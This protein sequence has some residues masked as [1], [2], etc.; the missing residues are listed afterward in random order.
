M[1]I[2]L[3]DAILYLRSD[4]SGLED[5]LKDA[6]KETRGWASNLGDTTK[7]LL[8]GAIVGGATVAAGAVVG[9]GAA[10]FT[11]SSNL[12][13][14]TNNIQAQLG[15]TEEEAQRLGDVAHAVW[16][17]NFGDDI[18]EAAAAVGLIRQQLGDLTDEELQD[19]AEAAFAIRDAFGVDVVE[20][21][22]AARTLMEDFGLTSEEAMNF[23]ASGFQRGL[24]RSGDFLDTITEYSTQFANGGADASQFFSLMESGLQGGMLGTDKAADAFKEFRVRIQDGSKATSESLAML[25]IDANQLATAMSD[26]TITAADAWQLV[27]ERLN[28]VDDENIRMQAGVGLL[29]TQFEDLGTEAA[30][31]LSLAGTSLEELAGST[32]SLNV[33]YDNWPAMWESIKR[34]ITSA[35]IPVGDRLLSIANDA[36]PHVQAAF[37]WLAEV[38]P[39]WIDTALGVIT[40]LAER[41][42]GMREQAGSNLEQFRGLWEQVRDVVSGIVEGL[43]D[44]IDAVFGE[45]ARFMEENGNSIRGT[46][47]STWRQIQY[48]IDL[49]LQLIDATI[50]PALSGIADFIRSHSDE[51]QTV[52]GVAWD[53]IKATVGTALDIIAGILEAGLTIIEGDWSGAWEAI[54][55]RLLDI[56]DRWKPL[57]QSG[58]DAI[59]SVLRDAGTSLYNAG[60]GFVQSFWD[61]IAARWDQMRDDFA[62]RLQGIRDLLPGSEPKD[63]SSPLYGLKEAGGAIVEN[64]ADGISDRRNELKDALLNLV[65]QIRGGLSGEALR[66]A[67]SRLPRS[68]A[69]LVQMSPDE[70]SGLF[71]APTNVPPPEATRNYRNLHHQFKWQD[72]G[73]VGSSGPGVINYIFNAEDASGLRDLEREHRV[74][75]L[76]ERAY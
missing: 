13:D 47:E 31:G 17:N 42:R 68:T 45:V 56:V 10:A 67:Y 50:G 57:V 37:T 8:T 40:A 21:T 26:G 34:S 43:G 7:T 15:A 22:D 4:K 39:G 29:G 27:N 76:L 32:E 11:A 23:I 64:V 2:T 66:A 51:I 14:A 5:G 55:N 65:N 20:S 44:L 71:G 30:L 6:E 25:G 36:M 49:A 75:T 52:L 59:L 74:R 19:A 28:E 16:R 35:L 3:G 18:G 54:K 1:A 38:L 24:N 12:R 58:I 63:T 62:A 72:A 48:I 61:G 53:I 41:I 33:Q 46:V 70:L 60:V 69:E 73:A 9:I